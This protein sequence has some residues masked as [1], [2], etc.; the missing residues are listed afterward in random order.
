MAYIHTPTEGN[1]LNRPLFFD[2]SNFMT[3]KKK[4]SI[5]IRAHD[6][7]IWKI[8]ALGPTIPK[9]A[10]GSL[11]SFEEYDDTD[12]RNDHYNRKA[13]QLLYCALNPKDFNRISSCDTAK[14]IWKML[15]I[16]HEGTSQVKETKINMLLHEYELFTMKDEESITTML[17]RFSVITNGLASFGKPI[18]SSD[19]AKKI[20]RSLPR[21]WDATVT[22]I[23][24]SKDLNTME[25]S[26][27]IGSLINYEIVIKSRNTKPKPKERER[28]ISDNAK[29]AAA[30]TPNKHEDSLN[31]K[32]I[33][34]IDSILPQ[35][36]IPF[37]DEWLAAVEAAEEDILTKKSGAV[38]NSPPDKSLPEPGPWS[39]W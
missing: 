31:D 16:T 8:I 33:L 35:K 29:V 24:E 17:D 12:W 25:F 30:V 21:D 19:K 10:D 4:M 5:F 39:P 34:S 38:Q 3:W 7:E 13:T 14:E 22:A 9:K 11:K 23:M 2:G 32:S 37:S 36:A 18:S 27:L 26:A 1:A 28:P 15:E 20:L 6:I